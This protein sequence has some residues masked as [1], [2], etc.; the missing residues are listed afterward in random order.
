M[1]TRSIGSL[2]YNRRK[3]LGLTQVQL[4]TLTGV[5][6][7][8]ISQIEL[9]KVRQPGLDVIDALARPLGL[10]ESDTRRALGWVVLIGE[11]V[12]LPVIGRVPA[13]SMRFTSGK[14][15]ASMP[16]IM[17]TRQQLGHTVSPFGLEVSGDCFSNIGIL[18]GD[19]VIIDAAQGRQPENHQII[20]VRVGSDVTL[21]RWVEV[22]GY[23]ELRD[24]SGEIRYRIDPDD[25]GNNLEVVG[26]YVTFI[27]LAKR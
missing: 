21:K 26:F 8:Y 7:N 27:P 16:E 23:V 6:Q 4:A 20:V 19:V 22:D 14:A 15:G 1:S 5:P 24:G 18:D 25:P 10:S 17:V 3:E 11:E 2:I 9:N 13:D 12:R